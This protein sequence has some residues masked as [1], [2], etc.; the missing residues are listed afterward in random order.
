MLAYTTFSDFF[1]L[2]SVFEF[3]TYVGGLLLLLAVPA[4]YVTL[5]AIRER[6]NRAHRADFH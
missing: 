6:K 4:L 5:T 2:P 1:Y 3:V